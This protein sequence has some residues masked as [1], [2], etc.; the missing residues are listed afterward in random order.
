MYVR[1]TTSF[2]GERTD[3]NKNYVPASF[4]NEKRLS[5]SEKIHVWENCTVSSKGCEVK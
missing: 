4:V 5:V 2:A 1:M 3:I